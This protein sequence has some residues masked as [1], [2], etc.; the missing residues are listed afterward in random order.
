LFQCRT[1]QAKNRK[2]MGILQDHNRKMTRRQ[3]ESIDKI[4]VPP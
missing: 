2:S 3:A 4:L 1:G